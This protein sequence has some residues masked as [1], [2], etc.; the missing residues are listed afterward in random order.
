MDL[1]TQI[2]KMAL[3][4]RL[5]RL[6]EHMTDNAAEVFKMYGVDLKPKWFPVYYVLANGEEKTV[7][8]IA[9]EIGHSHP[10]ISKIVTEMSRHGFVLEKKDSRDGRRNLVRLSKKGNE[11]TARISQPYEDVN[12]VIDE[13]LSQ[14]RH[15]LWKAIEE[16]E[17]M[18]EQ[19]PYLERIKEIKKQRE[20]KDVKIVDFQPK[21]KKAFKEL[22][23]EWIST[24]FKME[25][26]DLKLI[27]NPEKNIISK[28]GHIFVALYHDKPV[29]VC[30]LVKMNDPEFDYELSKMAVS[31]AAQGKNI[32]RLLALAIIE[33][34]KSLGASKLY[35]ESNTILKPAISLYY[36]LGFKK[37][38]RKHPSPYER[39]NIQ[40]ELDLE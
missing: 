37:I 38:L 6:S 4:S 23:A 29:G 27:D 35:I 36:K 21:Y 40:M 14:A 30:A 10:F 31:P 28:G 5:R 25:A 22:N 15:D 16:W 32:G 8:A 33:K 9:E 2:G 17:S 20:S 7:T 11:I 1:F 24:Y 39:C 3:G 34:A 19:K 13:I 18:L 12:K 26:A